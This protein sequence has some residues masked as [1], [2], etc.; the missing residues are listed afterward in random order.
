MSDPAVIEGPASPIC[1]EGDSFEGAPVLTGRSGGRYV[2]GSN[3]GR[4]Y[5]KR[6]AS[7]VVKRTFGGKP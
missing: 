6:G 5:L 1:G 3:G 4:T 7:G 2:V